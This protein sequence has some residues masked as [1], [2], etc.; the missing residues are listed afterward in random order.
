MTNPIIPTTM[1]K[2]DIKEEPPPMT[3]I[4]RHIPI[5][6]INAEIIPNVYVKIVAGSLARLSSFRNATIFEASFGA[7]SFASCSA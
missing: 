3:F 7:Y 2:T 5:P 1:P 4:E 6:V